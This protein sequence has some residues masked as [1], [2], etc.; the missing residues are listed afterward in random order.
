M[1]VYETGSRRFKS[2]RD[3]Q[4]CCSKLWAF[5]STDRIVRYERTDIGSIPIG[6]TIIFDVVADVTS[7]SASDRFVKDRERH[8]YRPVVQR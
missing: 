7:Y 6:P 4:V 5:R 2:Y 1:P 3:Y 8:Q